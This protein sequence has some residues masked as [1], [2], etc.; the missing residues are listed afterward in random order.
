MRK[1]VSILMLLITTFILIGCNKTNEKKEI[2]ISI[3]S[4]L[5]ES[6]NE[7][8]FLYEKEN[9]LIININSGSSGSL[10]KQ[11]SN[12]AKADM[13]FSANESYIDELVNEGL[14]NKE[15]VIKP[16]GNSL[17]LVKNNSS[18]GNI[19]E[20]KDLNSENIKIAIGEVGTVPAGQY[21][22]ETL[23]NVG[24]WNDVKEN[25][26]YTKDVEAVKKYVETGDVDYGFIY[27]S[28]STTLKNSSIVLEI[29]NDMHKEIVYS[30][31]MINTSEYKEETK[32][33]IDFINSKKGKEI[34]DRYG[35]KSY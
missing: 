13:F 8:K 21:A 18:S 20:L 7:I 28:D 29:P 2:T 3:A 35:F 9:D 33:L 25:L 30:M 14:I 6:M 11:I 10:K 32:D 26:I 24:I 5:V 15:D 34:F 1:K 22:K 16:I 17:V 23:E 4:S 19:N 31:A 27:K 12:G